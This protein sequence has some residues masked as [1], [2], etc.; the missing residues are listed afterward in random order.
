MV[1]K[2]KLQFLKISCMV[3]VFGV[4]NQIASYDVFCTDYN[5]RKIH[6]SIRNCVL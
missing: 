1:R 2:T 5:A 6:F 4:S 3:V